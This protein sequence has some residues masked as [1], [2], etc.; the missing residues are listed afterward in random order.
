MSGEEMQDLYHEVIEL[1]LAHAKAE[2]EVMAARNNAT[3]IV[4]RLT[5]AHKRLKATVAELESKLP[6]EVTR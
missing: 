6:K 4:N 1:S 3:T 2:Q 5:E